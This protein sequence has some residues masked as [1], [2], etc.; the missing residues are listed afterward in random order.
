MEINKSLNILGIQTKESPK[1]TKKIV[2]GFGVGSKIIRVANTLEENIEKGISD[3][4]NHS[5]F[6]IEKTGRE[7]KEKFQENKEKEEIKKQVIL[8]DLALLLSQISIIPTEEASCW[9]LKG[10][11]AIK[12]FLPKIFKS[13][14]IWDKICCDD[15]ALRSSLLTPETE[16]VQVADD[17]KKLMRKYNDLV[18]NYIDTLVEITYLN[19]LI[20][21]LSDEKEYSLSPEQLVSLGF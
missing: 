7:I 12:S 20:N 10:A 11:E 13:E 4:F 9:R 15:L 17:I 8:N 6:T 1:I 3:S 5:K 18:Y 2:K 14:L 21:N 16:N 19:S